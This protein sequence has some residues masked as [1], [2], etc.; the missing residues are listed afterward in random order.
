MKFLGVAGMLGMLSRTVLGDVCDFW[1]KILASFYLYPG[2]LNE[3]N[4]DITNQFIC[5]GNVCR[6]A[7]K[8]VQE[9]AN[10]KAVMTT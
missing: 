5:K 10:N 9:S 8:L 4:V 2:N 1:P 6:Q 7:Q 3:L